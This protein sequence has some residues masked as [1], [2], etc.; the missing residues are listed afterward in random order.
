VV[1][2]YFFPLQA[3]LECFWNHNEL[4]MIITNWNMMIVWPKV[5]ACLAHNGY[6]VHNI[7]DPNIAYY[8]TRR[9]ILTIPTSNCW[10]CRC[11]MCRL[12]GIIRCTFPMNLIDFSISH[13][14]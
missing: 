13:L 10:M 2:L 8:H 1:V 4:I 6:L 12:K 9:G 11:N 7:I 5:D 14:K 3:S